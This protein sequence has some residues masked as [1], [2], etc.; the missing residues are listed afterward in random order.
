MAKYFIHND[1]QELTK[2][3][4]LLGNVPSGW[5]VVDYQNSGEQ[6]D[7]SDAAIAIESSTGIGISGH[8]SIV[9]QLNLSDR[10]YK[11]DGSK[12]TT[13]RSLQWRCIHI[14][15]SWSWTDITEAM[16]EFV[17][18]NDTNHTALLDED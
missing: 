13:D 7:I 5:T 16:A 15:L 11:E 12:N 1:E 10:L 6:A 2:G 18:L 4:N 14:D 8:P 3:H 9:V 17:T